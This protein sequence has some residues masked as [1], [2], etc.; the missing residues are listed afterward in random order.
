MLF[1]HPHPLS[2]HDI[3]DVK[4]VMLKDAAPQH[5]AHRGFECHLLAVKFV[6]DSN[7]SAIFAK[8]IDGSFNLGPFG[9]I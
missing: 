3:M 6:G 4:S 8:A 9:I 7:N 1:G 2:G 5:T